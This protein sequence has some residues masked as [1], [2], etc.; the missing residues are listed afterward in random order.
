MLLPSLSTAVLVAEMV[1]HFYPKLV[2]LHNYRCDQFR[3]FRL[4]APYLKNLCSHSPSSCQSEQQPQPNQHLISN[5]LCSRC[6]SLQPSLDRLRAIVLL[7]YACLAGL[8]AA[9]SSPAVIAHSSAHGFL[10]SNIT[11]VLQ[12]LLACM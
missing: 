10:E 6:E 2:E 5:P 12:L 4:P 1:A 11:H 3:L 9:V 7:A 8:Q